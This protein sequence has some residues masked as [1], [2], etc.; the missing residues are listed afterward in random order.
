MDDDTSPPA[1]SLPAPPEPARRRRHSREWGPGD[2]TPN[3]SLTFLVTWGLIGGSIGALWYSSRITG[4]ATWWLGPESD[5][6]WWLHP[7]PFLAP[8][9]LS[10]LAIAVVRHLHWYGIA[11]AVATALVAVGDLT[12]VPGYAA[13]EFALAAAG[14]AVSVAAMS[15]ALRSDDTPGD[16]PVDTPGRTA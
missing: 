4:L 14:L 16:D 1:I 9:I 10:V 5:P 6:R 3:W 2:L 11:G 15:G 7:V 13:A 8:V 12:T